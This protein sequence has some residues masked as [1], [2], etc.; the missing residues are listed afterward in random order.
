MNNIG[1][2]YKGLPELYM[3]PKIKHAKS[4]IIKEIRYFS[5]INI[6]SYNYVLIKAFP[7]QAYAMDD[8]YKYIITQIE[9]KK[10]IVKNDFMCVT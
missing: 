4:D 3:Y 10:I 7:H 5:K 1:D 2:D 8:Y 6:N 9:N